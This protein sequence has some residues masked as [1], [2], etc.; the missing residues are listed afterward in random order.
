M[1]EVVCKG[2]KMRALLI[3]KKLNFR[4]TA[5][6]GVEQ[7]ELVF[8]RHTVQDTRTDSTTRFSK[9]QPPTQGDKAGGVKGLQ[10]LVVEIVVGV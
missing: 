2:S 7:L 8:P 10:G 6:T 1:S 9:D 3:I 5:K 4:L